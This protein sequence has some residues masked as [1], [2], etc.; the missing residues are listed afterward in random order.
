MPSCNIFTG[1]TMNKLSNIQCDVTIIIHACSYQT[2]N[3]HNILKVCVHG[4]FRH[5][6]SCIKFQILHYRKL[7]VELKLMIW[8]HVKIINSAKCVITS[9]RWIKWCF[10]APFALSAS[11]IL[12][13]TVILDPLREVIN[14]TQEIDTKCNSLKRLQKRN[15]T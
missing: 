2:P 13:S 3:M 10:F 9:S 8:I 1:V 12:D 14:Q 11:H 6:V 7:F 4:I 5:R 15:S